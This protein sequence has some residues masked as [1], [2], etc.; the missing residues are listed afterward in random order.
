[1]R[2]LYKIVVFL[3]TASASASPAR[4]GI[5]N[6]DC[7]YLEGADFL[8][9]ASEPTTD[10]AA[11]LAGAG[12]LEEAQS[13][14]RERASYE[15]AILNDILAL[16]LEDA[17][18]GERLLKAASWGSPEAAFWL[19][20]ANRSSLDYSLTEKARNRAV[21][22]FI[23]APQ[24][25]KTQYAIAFASSLMTI[26]DE[27]NA[28]QVAEAL[29][30]S[31]ITAN[32]SDY[33]NRANFIRG[34]IYQKQEADKEAI[35]HYG[36]LS[37]PWDD[38]VV[39][40]AKL[41]RIALSWSSG[42][43]RTPEA[44]ALLEEIDRDWRGDDL[45]ARI[46]LALARAYI[47]DDKLYQSFLVLDRLSH[48]SAPKEY[49]RVARHRLKLL[50]LEIFTS[51]AQE[52]PLIAQLDI[53]EKLN[54]HELTRDERIAID[55]A[56]ANWFASQGLHANA[57]DILGAYD[58]SILSRAG[59]DAALAAAETL[60]AVN[61]R[62]R[63]VETLSAVEG[64]SLSQINHLKLDL[65]H[66]R[67]KLP[68]VPTTD[69]SPELLSIIAEEAWRQGL[70]DIYHT[71]QTDAGVSDDGFPRLAIAAYL[72]HGMRPPLV[73]HDISSMSPILAALAP[74]E[75]AGAKKAADLHPLLSGAQSVLALAPLLPFP[76]RWLVD[77]EHAAPPTSLEQG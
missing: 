13:A 43:L 42:A 20:A 52:C 22:F 28:L 65:L 61:Q 4:A 25:V 40:E 59:A 44:V 2:Y 62:A 33:E 3:L 23:G 74:Q 39:V 37:L 10:R 38:P 53:Y 57:A 24:W 32:A 76:D 63:A 77:E 47:F 9:A 19:L 72:A 30:L 18:P 60:I 56:A 55:I 31:S 34:A 11:C 17:P 64:S 54:D 73:R 48:S 41:R 14:L 45:G 67:L 71:L 5:M 58:V 68:S 15:E 29:E 12:F 36:K 8:K 6:F 46:R 7:A 69:A 75:V 66:A 1:M 49:A 16:L 35:A 51:R 50:A 26:G 70:W 27:A 21:A